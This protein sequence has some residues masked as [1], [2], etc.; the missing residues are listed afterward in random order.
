MYRYLRYLVSSNK[1]KPKEKNLYFV[2]ILKATK[3]SG[4][5][6]KWYGVGIDN[7]IIDYYMMRFCNISNRP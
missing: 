1:V 5:V 2:G 4:S 3:E 6:K 7:G